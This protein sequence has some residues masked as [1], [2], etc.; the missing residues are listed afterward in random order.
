MAYLRQMRVERMARLLASTNLSGVARSQTPI[1]LMVVE[2]ILNPEAGSDARLAEDG[3]IVGH[4]PRRLVAGDLAGIFDGPST[5][6]FDPDLPMVQPH[7]GKRP[8][9]TLIHHVVGS[10]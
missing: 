10:G 8:T 9:R 5:V 3:R 1:L 4:A 7:A 6:P 2:R